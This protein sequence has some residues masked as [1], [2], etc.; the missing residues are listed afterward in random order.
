MRPFFLSLA[1]CAIFVSAGVF[2]ATAQ[3]RQAEVEAATSAAKSWLALVDA[4]KYDEAWSASST[5][6][7]SAVPQGQFFHAVSAARE[8]LGKLVSRELKDARYAES[9]PGAPDGHYVVLRFATSFENKKL[10][11]ETITPALEPDGAWRVSGY[12]IK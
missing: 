6:M 12:Y 11:I 2:R 10:A 5:L 9:L 1:V 8:P 4:G 7:R 3:E